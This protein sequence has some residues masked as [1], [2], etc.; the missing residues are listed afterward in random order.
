MMSRAFLLQLGGDLYIVD[1][2]LP[3]DGG[4]MGGLGLDGGGDR[5]QLQAGRGEVLP[6]MVPFESENPGHDRKD[7]D[8]DKPPETDG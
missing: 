7:R 2:P 5:L 6:G 4:G 1:L 3:V 8:R